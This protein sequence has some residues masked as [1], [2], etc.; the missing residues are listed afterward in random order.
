MWLH[1]ISNHLTWLHKLPYTLFYKQHQV[2]IGSKSI[3][4]KMKMKKD[5]IDT[6]EI[7]LD[8]CMNINIKFI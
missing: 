1:L 2:E 7:D 5:H 3:I 6:V 8:L 4:M